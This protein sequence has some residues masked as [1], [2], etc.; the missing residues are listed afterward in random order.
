MVETDRI[1]EN[2]VFDEEI[3]TKQRSHV[4]RR[5]SE[6]ANKDDSPKTELKKSQVI[7]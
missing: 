1:T 2:S 6:A 4:T 7:I 3:P 5:F